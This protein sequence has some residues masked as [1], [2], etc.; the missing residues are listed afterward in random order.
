MAAVSAQKLRQVAAVLACF[1]AL[2]VACQQPGPAF[3][4]S[5]AD[6][7]EPQFYSLSD[8]PHPFR[9]MQEEAQ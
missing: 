5:P 7:E 1:A 8:A 6:L 3:A 4:K 9:K 2:E